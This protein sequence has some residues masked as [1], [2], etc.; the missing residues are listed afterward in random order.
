MVGHAE[1]LRL[2][3]QGN[4]G[5][6]LVDRH[7]MEERPGLHARHLRRNGQP[8]FLKQ[9]GP[10]PRRGAAGMLTSRIRDLRTRLLARPRWQRVSLV[11]VVAL[12][13]G[14]TATLAR[15]PDRPP[16]GA[17][18]PV[19]EAGFV[20]TYGPMLPGDQLSVGSSHLWNTFSE[21]ATVESVALRPERPRGL[22][23]LGYRI[24]DVGPT[25]P[26]SLRSY[27]LPRSHALDDYQIRPYDESLPNHNAAVLIVGL[28]VD[29]GAPAV[30]STAL[31]SI[32]GRR[33][34][35]HAAP[36]QRH[37]ALRVRVQLGGLRRASRAVTRGPTLLFPRLP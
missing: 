10:H 26:H 4:H 8:D 37:H 25:A 15:H 12:G 19:I 21:P 7:R 23:L 35:V 33:Q 16:S 22:H 1:H 30:T 11:L 36:P 5:E 28:S 17:A 31:T 20:N 32:P 18:G 3:R 9:P 34:A 6:Q 27:P 14:A 29:T 13:A 24:M 2:C